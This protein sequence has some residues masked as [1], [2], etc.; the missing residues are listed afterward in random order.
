MKY[1]SSVSTEIQ[2]APLAEYIRAISS[3]STLSLITPFEGEAVL[4]S[5]IREHLFPERA[6][7]KS[8][9]SS[10]VRTRCSSSLKGS[11]FFEF[12][13]KVTVTK[14]AILLTGARVV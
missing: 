2:A 6:P 14:G 11:F 4:I 9:V 12:S 8:L 1:F 7:E 5:A 13:T 10:D 3:I